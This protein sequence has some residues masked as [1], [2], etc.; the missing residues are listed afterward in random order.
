M[1]IS[2]YF[3]NTH[4]LQTHPTIDGVQS[5]VAYSVIAPA[6]NSFTYYTISQGDVW[7]HYVQT[8]EEQ[9][10]ILQGCHV[11]PTAGHMG[12]EKTLYRIEERFMWKGMY[13]DVQELVCL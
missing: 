8:K 10:K 13:K 2:N 1:A 7:L 6:N 12:R 11:D 9:K 5:S 4:I 3:S